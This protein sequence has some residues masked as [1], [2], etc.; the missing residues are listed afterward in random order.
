MIHLKDAICKNYPPADVRSLQTNRR[1]HITRVTAEY[2]WLAQLAV[3]L[4]YRSGI[5]RQGELIY[6][7]TLVD[8]FAIMSK[9]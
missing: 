1:Q 4:V 7:L 6:I 2:S 3:Q 5:T 8:I 9:L